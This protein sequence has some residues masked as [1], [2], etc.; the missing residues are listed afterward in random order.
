MQRKNIQLEPS[1]IQKRAFIF[2][3]TMVVALIISAT[4]H[5]LVRVLLLMLLFCYVRKLFKRIGLQDN[6]A[7]RTLEYNILEGIFTLG[8]R[9][10][11]EE[12]HLRA[13]SFVHPKL[14]VLGF[15]PKVKDRPW[16][17]RSRYVLITRDMLS[18]DDFH[19]LLLQLQ[20]RQFKAV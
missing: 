5:L 14:I 9:A 16:F 6:R 7:I 12:A 17:R 4:I 20:L 8:Y 2:F 10:H 18:P 11:K 3:T 1:K 15:L 19:D 13:D